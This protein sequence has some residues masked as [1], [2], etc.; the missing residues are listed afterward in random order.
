[1]DMAMTAEA[2][3]EKAAEEAV[4]RAEA[5]LKDQLLGD[6]ESALVQASIAKSLAQLHV[7]RRRRNV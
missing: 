2:I 6:E 7:K 3:D 5:R 1:V 4:K